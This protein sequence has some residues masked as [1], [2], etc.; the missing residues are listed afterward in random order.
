MKKD[1]PSV[2]SIQNC[3]AENT[4]VQKDV[5]EAENL[6]AV[7]GF[8]VN[9]NPFRILGSEIHLQSEMLCPESDEEEEYVPLLDPRRHRT[10]NSV[11]S[12]SDSQESSADRSETDQNIYQQC[13]S[14]SI[15]KSESDQEI[16]VPSEKTPT[17]NP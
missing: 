7:F 9:S 1:G 12:L 15:S 6:P 8:P 3:S 5:Q 17:V 2:S 4:S 10:G 14:P 13:P 16:P 11:S